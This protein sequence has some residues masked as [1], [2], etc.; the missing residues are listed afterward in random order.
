MA[1]VLG[2]GFLQGTEGSDIIKTWYRTYVDTLVRAGGGDD[3]VVGGEGNDT[4]YGDGGSDRLEG[5][6]GDDLIYGGEG[7]DTLVAGGGNDTL[8]GEAGNDSLDGGGGNDLIEG[9]DGDD[10]I[11]G[12]WNDVGGEDTLYGG[13]GNDKL[14]GGKGDQA[15]D[16]LT[17]GEGADTFYFAVEGNDDDEYRGFGVD[18]ITDFEV[19]V[20]KI[21]V[22]DV[23]DVNSDFDAS[24]GEFRFIKFA[25]SGE[26]TYISLLARSGG[27][28]HGVAGTIILQGVQVSDVYSFFQQNMIAWPNPEY[29]DF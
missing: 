9:G 26:D 24:S 7:N 23:H 15:N 11:D 5:R 29:G 28:D 21:N 13:A 17:G 22:V 16:V 19:G 14:Q 10:R 18:I 3:L 12:G 8:Y 27:H 25:V 2:E 4:V 6:G 1:E 20:D